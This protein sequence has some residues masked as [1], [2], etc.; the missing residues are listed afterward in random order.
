MYLIYHQIL[1]GPALIFLKNY[2]FK[3]QNEIQDMH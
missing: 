3:V 1:L 2:A